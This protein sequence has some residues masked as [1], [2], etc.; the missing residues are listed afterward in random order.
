MKR[1][2]A[3][4]GSSNVDF[5][6]KVQ[7][8]PRR[9]ET[10]TDGVFLQTFGGKGANQAVAA[11]RAGGRVTFVTC[12]GDDPYAP[13]MIAN[14]RADGMD[15]SRVVCLPGESCGSALVMLDQGGDNYLTVAPGANAGL[16]PE[17]VRQHADLIR[18]S[19]MVILQMEVPVA[20]DREVLRLA[21][22]SGTRVLLNYAPARDP[23]LAVDSTVTGLVVNEVEA[24]QL[25]DTQVESTDA[26][27]EAARALVRLGPG[28]VVLT[29][30]ATGVVVADRQGAR[31]VPGFAVTPVDTTGAG[32]TFCG[33]LAVALVEG[34]SLEAA[35]SFA[36]AAAAIS[37]TR[38]GAQPSIPRRQEIDAF[39][40]RRDPPGDCA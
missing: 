33:A 26:A 24:G 5:I 27:M 15:T 14:F 6:M 40:A 25:L 11:A 12:L 34:R 2:I 3:V 36:N 23:A 9:G 13:R 32:D 35:G 22:E 7:A 8:L 30:G 20:A 38:L 31:R 1:G 17:V 10:V 4:F 21:A 39:L 18:D 19:A 16:T 28:F 29:L 37:V